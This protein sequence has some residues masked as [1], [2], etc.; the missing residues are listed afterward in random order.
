MVA[1][2]SRCAQF[3]AARHLLALASRSS[4]IVQ[5]ELAGLKGGVFAHRLGQREK[6]TCRLDANW[7]A[8]SESERVFH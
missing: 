8:L 4:Q 2:I 5:L 1:G 7:R 3:M 6:R